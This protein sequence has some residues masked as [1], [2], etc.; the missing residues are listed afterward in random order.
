MPVCHI[1]CNMPHPYMY[2]LGSVPYGM[3]IRAGEVISAEQA[4]ERSAAYHHME[5]QPH[6]YFMNLRYVP[7][8]LH[9]LHVRRMPLPGQQMTLFLMGCLRQHS[10]QS[11]GTAPTRQNLQG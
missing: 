3:S 10:M 9:H 7:A 1:P 6:T 8:V 5:E 2:M 11:F 4:A